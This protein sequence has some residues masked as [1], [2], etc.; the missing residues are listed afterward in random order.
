M[1]EVVALPVN[2]I[3]RMR[4]T[5]GEWINIHRIGRLRKEGGPGITWTCSGCKPGRSG[6]RYAT[7]CRHI[8]AILNGHVTEDENDTSYATDQSGRSVPR[9]LVELTPLG[10]DLL[11]ERWAIAA[12]KR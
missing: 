3:C 7:L 12:L 9:R 2:L 10:E 1:E 6:P 11:R 8:R 5:T 4:K